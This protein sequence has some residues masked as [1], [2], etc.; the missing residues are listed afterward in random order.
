MNCL[1]CSSLQGR[2]WRWAES[3]TEVG[4]HSSQP[5]GFSQAKEGLS[6]LRKSKSR[7][8]H[9]KY[10]LSALG[11]PSWSS[12]EFLRLPWRQECPMPLW[13]QDLCMQT[14]SIIQV[15][16]R[17]SDI[18]FQSWGFGLD[19][20]TFMSCSIWGLILKTGPQMCCCGR[21]IRKEIQRNQ[22]LNVL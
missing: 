14:G 11:C 1:I 16:C 18:S 10:L 6:G 5:V 19:L 9:G 13:S 22:S 21:F 4:Q 8:L 2:P 17:Y 20:P 7:G 15:T 3:V 12:S